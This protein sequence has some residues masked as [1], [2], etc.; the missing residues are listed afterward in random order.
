MFHF[1]L[2][3]I[4]SMKLF[5]T[6]LFLLGLN[7]SVHATEPQNVPLKRV[8]ILG[9]DDHAMEPFITRDGRYLLFNNLNQPPVNTDI[10]Y[11]ERQDD[12]TWRYRGKVGGINTPA[13]EGC[14]TMDRAGKI[15]F[16]SPRSYP[17]TLCTIYSGNFKDG[18][19]TDVR[20]VESI[21]LKKP[22]LVNFD[23]DVS[24]DGKM[25][26]FVDSHFTPGTGPTKADLVIAFWNGTQFVRSPDSARLLSQVNTAGLQYAP[27]IS[28][29]KL[30]LYF[31]RMDHN[32]NF[33]GPQIYRATR[34]NV[35]SPFG[36][37]QHMEGLGDFVEGPA[38]SAN[39]RLLYF[40]RT[41]GERFNLY[42]MQIP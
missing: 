38:F 6:L 2:A 23:V 27:A 7:A 24:P 40:H 30:T 9:Y 21:S 3:G 39:E 34:S 11:A 1:S 42:A 19:V 5:T 37:P 26:T 18:V 15:F 25:L 36:S 33:H 31:T 41:D 13:L 32:S 14:P 10:H 35:D 16:V 22:G 28:A 17:K 8:M 29:D 4:R 12:F 20:I